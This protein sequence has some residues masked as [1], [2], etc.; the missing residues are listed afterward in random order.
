VGREIA[1]AKIPVAGLRISR[2]RSVACAKAIAEKLPAERP[3]IVHS[4]LFHANFAVRLAI[5]RLKP[6]QRA[7][8]TV[9]STVHVVERRFRPWHF[10]LDYITASLARLEVCVS[11]AVAKYQQER[12][13]LDEKFFRV[14]PN[15]IDLT[16]FTPV[17]ISDQALTHPPR[18][19]SVGRLS[20][21]KDFSTLLR[22]WK[23]IEAARPDATLAIAGSGPDEASL[24]A[25]AKSLRVKNVTFLGQVDNI[26]EVF[27]RADVY[28]Q[29]SAWEGFG[30]TVAEAMATGLPVVVT[31]ADS[32]PELVTHEKTGWVVPKERPEPIAKAVLRLISDRALAQMLGVHAR[33]EALQRFSIDRMVADYAALYRELLNE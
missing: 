22:A 9:V 16:R 17:K 11:R 15:G 19:L 7:G 23:I 1:A 18:V 5:K 30:L 12:T 13:G 24:L 8:I 20:A 32:L 31:D 14:I 33:D 25:Q 4:H 6:E 3:L 10:S 21:Q 28:V 26:P 27:A 29:S 2:R